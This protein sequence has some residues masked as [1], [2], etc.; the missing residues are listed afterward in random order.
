[1]L[2]RLGGRAKGSEGIERQMHIDVQCVRVS[3]GTT[4]NLCYVATSRETGEAILIDPAWELEAIERCVAAQQAHVVAVL[5]THSHF[6]H[7]NLADVCAARYGVPVFMAED[8]ADFYGYVSRHL[9]PIRQSTLRLG[10]LEVTVLP[11]PGHT[12]ASRCFLIG[13]ALFTGDTL[14]TEGCG[15]CSGKGGSAAAMF[16]S[17]RLLKA[18]L[19]HH[20][21]VFPGHSFGQAPGQTFSR[22]LRHNVYLGMEDRDQFVQFR[23]RPNQRPYRFQ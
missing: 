19:P 10:K 3:Y 6:D 21:C 2:Q 16:E 15:I 9:E 11:T 20:A 8:E 4:R 23:M 1:M 5:L 13:D 17:M 7:I 12:H 18:E 22:L 14:F